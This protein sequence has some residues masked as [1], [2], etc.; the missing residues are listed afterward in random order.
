MVV[1]AN[2]F[3]FVGCVLH[4]END[5]DPQGGGIDRSKLMVMFGLEM[6][7]P[8][9]LQ[10]ECQV[11]ITGVYTI[12]GRSGGGI[13]SDTFTFDNETGPIDGASG[14]MFDRILKVVKTAQSPTQIPSNAV[15]G[16]HEKSSG[17]NKGYLYGSGRSISGVEIVEVR[18]M[19]L[20]ATRPGV[21]SPPTEKDV[22]EKIFM[23]NASP[24][25]TLS[26]GEV[27]KT[28]D[29]GALIAF[30]VADSIDD[31]EQTANRLTAPTS[32]STFDSQDKTIPDG[33][34]PAGGS[35]APGEAIGVWFR[36]RLYSYHLTGTGSF[37]CQIR[38]EG[39]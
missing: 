5:S 17:L 21:T 24:T 8:D 15:V 37:N 18:R 36:L 9:L 27:R 4:A 20:G 33:S 28:A 31:S 34:S 1:N 16:F 3:F 10:M 26:G 30:A 2:N 23:L 12:T 29:P 35:L 39:L 32:V 22:F 7:G 13:V 11:A 19:Y 38:G 6:T 14:T 25:G